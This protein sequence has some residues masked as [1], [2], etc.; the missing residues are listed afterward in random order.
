MKAVIFSG[1]KGDP[2]VVC[3]YKTIDKP[4]PGKDQVLVR[5][6][7][8]PCHPSTLAGVTPTSYPGPAAGSALGS[9]G[10][11]V[12]EEHGEGCSNPP[13]GARVLVLGVG[14]WQEYIALP[15][16][17]LVVV[18]DG[19]SNSNAA[20]F[21]VNPMSAYLMTTKFLT[22]Q[23]GEW[24]LQ[25]AA[26]SALGKV[27]I[28]IGKALGF[29][30]I[31]VVRSE[32][33]KAELLAAGGDEVIVTAKEKISERVAA[34]TG[35]N[36]VKYA[37]DCVGGE[38]TSDILQSLSFKGKLVIFGELAHEDIHFR[39]GLMVVKLLTIEGFW[40]TDWS[41]TAPPEER[42][43]CFQGLM[44]LFLSGKVDCSVGKEFELKDFAEAFKA[45]AD[46]KSG[47]GGK[48]IMKCS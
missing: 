5:M 2:A 47:G 25:T 34:I 44:E 29:R 3:S 32:S 41:K 15:A 8:S 36:G 35:G 16:A 13:K 26:G 23:K 30:T 7:Y 37:I 39:S 22:P 45:S 20:Q 19:L 46:S 4:K 11:G 48:V 33:S 31:N 38:Q 9:E 1:T 10:V 17:T 42:K 43:K 14:N 27:V 12:V 24:L 40:L 21:Y 6:L 28:Q 18:P